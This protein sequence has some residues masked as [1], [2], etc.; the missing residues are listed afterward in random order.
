MF[1][2]WFWAKGTAKNFKMKFQADSATAVTSSSGKESIVDS[3]NLTLEQK[4]DRY[5]KYNET[6]KNSVRP[7]MRPR[8]VASSHPMSGASPPPVTGPWQDP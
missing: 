4:I 5:I 2:Y 8:M 6:G 1:E 7:S 3:L